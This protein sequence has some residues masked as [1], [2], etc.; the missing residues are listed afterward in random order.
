MLV[1]LAVVASLLH[2]A[3]TEYSAVSN[4]RN[5]ERYVTF[6]YGSPPD[7][8]KFAALDYDGTL[9]VA[10]NWTNINYTWTPA[11][12]LELW[13]S[14]WVIPGTKS[15]WWWGYSQ[16]RPTFSS[17]P[18]TVAKYHDAGFKIVIMSNQYVLSRQFSSEWDQPPSEKVKVWV[19]KLTELCQ[20]IEKEAGRRIPIHVIGSL[21]QDEGT[22]PCVG[23]LREALT[24]N[25][26]IQKLDCSKSFYVGDAAGRVRGTTTSPD[27]GDFSAGDAQ[28]AV[29]MNFSYY[30]PEQFFA[31]QQ[32]PPVRDLN[33]KMRWPAHGW[34]DAETLPKTW[35]K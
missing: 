32:A 21:W 29:S 12:G 35:C 14:E 8:D 20:W 26:D 11:P 22:K 31:A 7:S 6:D 19:H 34:C 9:G 2:P 13:E 28:F 10:A 15:V 25:G 1:R 5:D 30:T 17:I 4:L 27:G 23:M 33:A 24:S 18:A 16:W 3:R